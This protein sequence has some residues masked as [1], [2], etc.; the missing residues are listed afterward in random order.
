M[1]GDGG[2]VTAEVTSGVKV[3]HDDD[4][5]DDAETT[6]RKGEQAGAGWEMESNDARNRESGVRGVRFWSDISVKVNVNITAFGYSASVRCEN[7]M[8]NYEVAGN[9]TRWRPDRQQ[10]RA[11]VACMSHSSDREYHAGQS[12]GQQGYTLEVLLG[13]GQSVEQP[14]WIRWL[15]FL[16][17]VCDKCSKM[18]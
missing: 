5:D 6:P 10:Y 9:V 3:E 18:L 11:H 17:W 2:M 14:S 16:C 15:E 7:V 4:D 8:V 1:D 12:W 13:C